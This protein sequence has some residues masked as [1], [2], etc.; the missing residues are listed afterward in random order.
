MG[1]QCKLVYRRLFLK[2]VATMSIFDPLVLAT[3]M[4]FFLVL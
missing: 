3:E 4:Y 1:L 2:S